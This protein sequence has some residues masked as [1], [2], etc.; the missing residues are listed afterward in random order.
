MSEEG[1]RQGDNAAMNMNSCSIRPLIDHL[2]KEE[3]YAANR[4]E[5]AKQA[6][7]TDD[8]SAAGTLQSIAIWFNELFEKGPR[9]GYFPNP[10]K[11]HVIVKNEESLERAIEFFRGSG[12]KFTLHGRP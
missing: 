12:V 5:K 7:Y 10:S 3:I 4:A 9:V 11:C 1:S 6:C 8:S 2:G